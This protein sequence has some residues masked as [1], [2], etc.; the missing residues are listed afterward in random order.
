MGKIA[1]LVGGIALIRHQILH[2]HGV[3]LGVIAGVVNAVIGS[4]DG[5]PGAGGEE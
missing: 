5:E 4:L 1:Y 3:E 2:R